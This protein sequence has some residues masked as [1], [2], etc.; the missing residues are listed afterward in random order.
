MQFVRKTEN[1]KWTCHKAKEKM[2]NNLIHPKNLKLFCRSFSVN[3]R[4]TVISEELS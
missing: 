2:L 4:N 3:K 1:P